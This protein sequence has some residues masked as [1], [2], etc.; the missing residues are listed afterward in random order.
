MSSARVQASTQIWLD[1]FAGDFAA[2][3]ATMTRLSTASAAI[4]FVVKPVLASL[5]DVYGRRPLLLLPPVLN[6][7]LKAAMVFAPHA[8][9]VQLL[10]AQHLLGAFTWEVRGP[11]NRLRIA[12]PCSVAPGRR[13][14]RSPQSSLTRTPGATQ[15]SMIASDAALGDMFS[16]RHPA[17]L[18]RWIGLVRRRRRRRRRRRPEDHSPPPPPPP[19][20]GAVACPR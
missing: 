15:A 20:P 9:N 11:K 13:R 10:R 18:G 1:H 19:A 16:E 8:A 3:A 12:A 4:G 14:R 5:S 6:T 7:A 2:H 17:E